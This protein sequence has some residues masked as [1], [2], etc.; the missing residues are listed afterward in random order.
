MLNFSLKKTNVDETAA[1]RKE[2]GGTEQETEG[3]R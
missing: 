2:R 1:T 3:G